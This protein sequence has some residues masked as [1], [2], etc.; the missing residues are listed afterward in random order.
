MKYQ[1]KILICAY[2]FQ[3]S[4]NFERIER[5]KT[6]NK[7]TEICQEF[8]LKNLLEKIWYEINERP[9]PKVPHGQFQFS[10]ENFPRF[11]KKV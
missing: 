5:V 4:N 11:Q 9:N 7:A 6:G 8:G 3:F 2:Q 10:S 1:R